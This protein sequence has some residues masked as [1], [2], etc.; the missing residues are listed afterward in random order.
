TIL[1]TERPDRVVASLLVGRVA[2]L[3][4]GTPF[5]LVMPATVDEF[6]HSPDDYSQ[7]R[8]PMSLIRL[9]RYSSI[10]ITI[11]MPGL[12]ISL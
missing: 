9:L 8:I 7:R 3:V 5:A 4:V 1:S 2:I 12:Y 10:L 6:I 11:Y